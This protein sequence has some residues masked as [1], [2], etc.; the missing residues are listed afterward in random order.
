MLRILTALACLFVIGSELLAQENAPPAKVGGHLIIE[1]T[2]ELAKEYSRR[3]R[4]IDRPVSD[5]VHVSTS[6]TI[7]QKRPDGK[8]RIEHSSPI[9]RDGQP[10]RL[11]T[12]TAFVDPA[13]IKST[14]TPA[15]TLVSANPGAPGVA[16]TVETKGQRLQ[17]SDLKNVKLRTWTLAEEIGD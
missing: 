12:L 1:M 4:G 9:N 17:L 13:A 11:I 10:P 8:F 3:S 5:A 15:G 2:G 14:V 6:A 16:T 7:A